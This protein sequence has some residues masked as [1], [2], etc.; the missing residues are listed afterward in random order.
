MKGEGVIGGNKII[1]H[2]SECAS[3]LSDYSCDC[4]NSGWEH[5]CDAVLGTVRLWIDKCP[6]CGRPATNR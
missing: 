2:D 1:E 3:I 5:G 6:H 4:Y